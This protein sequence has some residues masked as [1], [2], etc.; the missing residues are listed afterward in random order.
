MLFPFLLLCHPPVRVM[1]RDTVKAVAAWTAPGC[2][3]VLCR[4]VT[5]ACR[6]IGVGAVLLFNSAGINSFWL[7]KSEEKE[8]CGEMLDFVEK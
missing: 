3:R 2:V 5:G 8:E 1:S 7:L 4:A 6:N